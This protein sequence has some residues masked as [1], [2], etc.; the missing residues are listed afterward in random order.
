MLLNVLNDYVLMMFSL[1]MVDYSMSFLSLVGGLQDFSVSPS[2]FG[3]TWGFELGWTGFGLGLGGLRT[4]GFRR[5][6]GR[7]ASR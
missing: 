7:E 1:N 3:T 5:R 6:R 2:P 4:K